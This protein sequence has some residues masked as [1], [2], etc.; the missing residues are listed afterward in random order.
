MAI[1]ID[2]NNTPTAG[3]IGYGDGTELAFTTAGSSGQVLTSAGSSAPTW[4]TPSAGALTFITSVTASNSATV[5]IE[6]AMTAYNVYVIE[7]VNIVNATDDTFLK[8]QL[9]IG[10]SYITTSTYLSAMAINVASGGAVAVDNAATV[11]TFIKFVPHM[12][13]TASRTASGSIKILSPSSTT[14]QKQVSFN[15]AWL[16]SS[17]YTDTVGNGYGSGVNSGT[18]AVT[19]VRI[20]SSSGNITSGTFR[21]YGI[22]NS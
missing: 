15:Y 2:G 1:V 11:T 8:I 18:G 4:T 21:L 6:D 14:I 5:D 22:A 16:D 12:S 19:G 10:G 3:G 20:F 13:N 7:A 9:K 17:A